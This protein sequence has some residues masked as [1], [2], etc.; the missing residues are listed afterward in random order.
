M[1]EKILNNGRDMFYVGTARG[2]RKHWKRLMDKY[3]PDA[4]VADVAK[5][6]LSE[7]KDANQG[8]AN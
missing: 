6:E 2:A 7:D 3:G 4:R 1:K 8:S 5:S